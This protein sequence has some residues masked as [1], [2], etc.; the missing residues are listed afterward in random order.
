M[1]VF[2]H[3]L[4]VF[5][6][7]PKCLASF[8]DRIGPEESNVRVSLFETSFH[9][10]I[11]ANTNRQWYAIKI[12]VG[13]RY[14][15]FNIILKLSSFVPF[16]PHNRRNFCL[17]FIHTTRIHA[18]KRFLCKGFTT[19]HHKCSI[20]HG[21]AQ[22]DTKWNN[23]YFIL[24]LMIAV[25]RIRSF[26]WAKLNHFWNLPCQNICVRTQRKWIHIFLNNTVKHYH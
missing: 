11:I 12:D 4:F 25:F 10:R 22:F 24:P 20:S 3:Y 16:I 21:R 1:A 13:W 15:F 2:L 18:T 6:D 8:V 26:Q 5:T 17:F 19:S 23:M 9:W 7:V 14:N